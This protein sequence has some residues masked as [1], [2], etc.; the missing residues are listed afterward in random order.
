MPCSPVTSLGSRLCLDAMTAQE[1]NPQ[2]Q[3]Y[4]YPPQAYPPQGYPPQAYPP[5]G[6]PPQAYPPQAYPPQAYPQQAYPQQPGL[7]AARRRGP[8]PAVVVA[9][10]LVVVALIG[11][12]VFSISTAVNEIDAVVDATVRACAPES[13]SAESCPVPRF[14]RGLSEAAANPKNGKFIGFVPSSR[15]VRCANGICDGRVR[16]NVVFEHRTFPTTLDFVERDDVWT[17]VSFID[18]YRPPLLD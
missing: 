1:P 17:L 13:G 3:H 2:Q 8:A 11:T 18:E 10:V 12:C 15:E 9:A 4:P 6:Y 16:G 7:G 5:Q 14:H